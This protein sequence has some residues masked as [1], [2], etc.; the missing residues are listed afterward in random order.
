[1]AIPDWTPPTLFV[2]GHLVTAAELN[3]LFSGNMNF[4]NAA[5]HCKVY[6]A[7][8][9]QSTTSSTVTPISFNGES[10]DP[11]GMHDNSVNPTRLTC[12][13]DLAGVWRFTGQ[14]Q[15]A[16]NATGIREL[17]LTLNGVLGIFAIRYYGAAT[18]SVSIWSIV[19]MTQLAAGDYVEL[20]VRQTSG[21]ALNVDF[22]ENITWL[23]AEWLGAIAS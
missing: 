16:S 18:G 1:M 5:K 22:G 8:S 15:F 14:V 2:A 9:A 19:G 10:A 4:L 3:P 21:G 11:W 12:P 7:T 23:D 20:S 13:A 6:R 17:Q